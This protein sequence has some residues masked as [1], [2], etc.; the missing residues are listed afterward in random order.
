VSTFNPFFKPVRA[1][2]IGVPSGTCKKK[3]A[4]HLDKGSCGL[5]LQEDPRAQCVWDRCAKEQTGGCRTNNYVPPIDRVYKA[6]LRRKTAK[7]QARGVNAAWQWDYQCTNRWSHCYIEDFGTYTTINP[8]G[9]NN[10]KNRNKC[11][12]GYVGRVWACLRLR[13]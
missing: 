9:Q 10:P 3:C 6:K 1:R 12:R 2:V 5:S 4:E 7:C 11:G 8:R 13:C